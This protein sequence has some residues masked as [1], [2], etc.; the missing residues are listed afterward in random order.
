MPRPL[1]PPPISPPAASP[2]TLGNKEQSDLA[3]S[4][5]LSSLPTR[6]ANALEAAIAI[7]KATENGSRDTTVANTIQALSELRLTGRAYQ[8]AVARLAN[9]YSAVDHETHHSLQPLAKAVVAGKPGA[10]DALSRATQARIQQLHAHKRVG[11]G[12]EALRQFCGWLRVIFNDAAQHL[13]GQVTAE[14]AWRRC[15]SFAMEV[16]TV[17]GVDHRSFDA[18][19]GRLTEYLGTDVSP[20]S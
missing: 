3:K 12:T 18:H 17:V 2:F 9:D 5:G 8:K 1:A 4:L 16:F 13:R 20:L 15:R 19:P 6:V 11:S 14:E 10:E 7:Y